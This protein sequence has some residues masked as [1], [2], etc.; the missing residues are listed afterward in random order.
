M[1]F[2]ISTNVNPD[3]SAAAIWESCKAYLRGEIISYLAYQRKIAVEN[4]VSLSKDIAE[5]Q[6]KCVDTPDADLFEELLTKKVEYVILVSNET[7]ESLLK[8]RH[9]YY[10]FG[11]K[12]SKLLAHQIRQSSSS[13]H[14]T[15]INTDTGITI[16][17]QSIN[18]QFR[19]FHASLYS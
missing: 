1:I 14:I 3:V 15:Q 4:K 13:L 6:S 18:N 7:A 8:T 16:N 10:E 5:L 11:D 9:N 19:D 12:P 2:F 17:P